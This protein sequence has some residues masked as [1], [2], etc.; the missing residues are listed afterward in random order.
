MWS[1]KH[2]I[3]KALE[4]HLIPWVEINIKQFDKPLIEQCVREHYYS[5]WLLWKNLPRDKVMQITPQF[6]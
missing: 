1:N 2:H 6:G 5:D 3:H 4:K